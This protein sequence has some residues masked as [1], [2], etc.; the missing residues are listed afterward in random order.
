MLENW[1]LLPPGWSRWLL[2]PAALAPLLLIALRRRLRDQPALEPLPAEGGAIGPRR[3]PSATLIVA[4]RDE[5][6]RL[7]DLLA[8]CERLLAAGSG[9]LDLLLV[10]DGSEDGSGETLEA[11]CRERGDATLLV[12]ERPLGK[13]ASLAR[14]TRR[15]RG[16]HLLFSDA[17]C[18][19]PVGWANELSTAL[20]DA[21]FVAGPVRLVEGAPRDSQSVWQ[22]LQWIALSG[23]AGLA[24]HS[25]R[26]ISVWGANFGLRRATL[27]EHGG[28]EALVAV[29]SGED[30]ELFR[31]LDARGVALSWL[32][33]PDATVSTALE[34]PAAAARQFGRWLDSLHRLPLAGWLA[35]LALDLTMV[36][37]LV[38]TA[39]RPLLGLLLAAA[40]LQALTALLDDFGR[41]MGEDR[42]RQ[43]DTA[44]WVL[45][46]PERL[47]AALRA[48]RRPDPG[49][50][51]RP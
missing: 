34:T 17:D 41:R 2:L 4:C 14:A 25:G 45:F 7:D 35:L 42:V 31:A 46:W 20:L 36:S 43:R 6:E 10:D 15:A 28:Y 5:S 40:G 24:A 3:L 38:T 48:R 44:L 50:G 16:A 32:E 47:F 11:W 30:L 26:P 1:L 13:P 27:E 12:N 23:C 22:R 49:W 9:R 51:P 8:D 19:L 21:E 37:L 18:R 29:E 33:G 39:V